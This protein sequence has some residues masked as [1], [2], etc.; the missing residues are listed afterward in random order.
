M[1]HKDRFVGLKGDDWGPD[2]ILVPGLG[3]PIGTPAPRSPIPIGD[4]GPT[5]SGQKFLETD[6]PILRGLLIADRPPPGRQRQMTPKVPLPSALCRIRTTPGHHPQPHDI[7]GG[8]PS[9]G[10]PE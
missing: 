3:I 6:S 1:H 5:A 2:G 8:H 9:P 7:P 4:A 10:P